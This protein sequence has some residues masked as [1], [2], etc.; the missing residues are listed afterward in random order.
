MAGI[1]NSPTG[2]ES[3]ASLSDHEK[4]ID[5]MRKTLSS[6]PSESQVSEVHVGREN[7]ADALPP[8]D[9]YEGLHRWD[10]QATWT[11]AEERK[12]VWK[13]DFYLLTWICVMVS[14]NLASS[15]AMFKY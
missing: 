8:H 5:P 11:E 15:F 7:L 13:T 9:S 3:K 14:E 1:V 10:P 2:E 12:L 6:G 4:P